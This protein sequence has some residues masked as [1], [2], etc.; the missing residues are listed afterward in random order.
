MFGAVFSTKE[1]GFPTKEPIGGFVYKKNSKVE[2]SDSPFLTTGQFSWTIPTINQIPIDPKFSTDWDEKQ[3]IPSTAQ[4]Q[5]NSKGEM[6]FGIPDTGK[7]LK[8]PPKAF[9]M[10]VLPYNEA[11]KKYATEYYKS[12]RDLPGRFYRRDELNTECDFEMACWIAQESLKLGEVWEKV[13]NKIKSEWKDTTVTLLPSVPLIRGSVDSGVDGLHNPITEKLLSGL[14]SENHFITYIPLGIPGHWIA[15][16]IYSHL[17][18]NVMINLYDPTGLMRWENHFLHG[19]T[20]EVTYN[21]P[22]NK[23]Y[24]W[25]EIVGQFTKSI[26]SLIRSNPHFTKKTIIEF[27]HCT[28]HY[29]EY[30]KVGLCS[31]FIIFTGWH[32]LTNPI[33]RMAS[34]DEVM[35]DIL[36]ISHANENMNWDLFQSKS[37]FMMNRTKNFEELCRLFRDKAKFIYRELGLTLPAK[38]RR[39][40]SKR[41]RRRSRR[42]RRKSRRGTYK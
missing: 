32:F 23:D 30:D 39:K 37:R 3:Q 31:L 35:I 40:R 7:A 6:I 26:L 13:M 20:G 34:A 27:T 16:G 42:S 1:A 10:E 14:Q 25:I 33:L 24:R 36:Q 29:Q 15:I 9:E 11:E 5:I 18:H 4:W 19:M 22:Y 17:P 21:S 41:S 8:M 28:E 38:Q 2:T 12:I